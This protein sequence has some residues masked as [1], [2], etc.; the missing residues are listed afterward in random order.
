MRA[1]LLRACREGVRAAGP[2]WRV[3]FFGTDRFAV[4]TLRAL[5]A[6]GYRPGTGERALR[7]DGA[8]REG[9]RGHGR[10]GREGGA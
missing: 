2:P 3:L 6:A 4:T 10:R 7:G 5:R 8:E 1:R 9:Q